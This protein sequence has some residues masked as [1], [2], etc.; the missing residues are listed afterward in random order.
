MTKQIFSEQGIP[1]IVRSDNGPHFEGQAYKEFAKQYG[2]RHITSSP[3]YARSNGFI[4]S[5]VKTTKRT[6]KK[7]KATKSDPFMALLCLR[8]TPINND[9]PSPAELLLGR[10]IQDNLPKKTS[11]AA[12]NKEVTNRLLQRQAAQKN[13][14]DR[15]TKPLPILKSGQSVNI[16]DPRTKTWKPADVKEKIQEA[17]RSYIVTRSEGREMRR[18]RTQLRERPRDPKDLQKQQDM[19]QNPGEKAPTMP[20]PLPQPSVN[21]EIHPYTTRSGRRVIPPTRLDV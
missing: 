19:D 16:Q 11:K 12:T 13:Y 20:E 8:A 18:N 21:Q 1:Q 10:P 6:M 9:L 2:F 3:H 17:P 7:A 14:H 5:Q 15:N 4:E